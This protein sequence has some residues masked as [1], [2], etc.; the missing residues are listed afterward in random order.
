LDTDLQLITQIYAV[1]FKKSLSAVASKICRYETVI[2]VWKWQWNIV[3]YKNIYYIHSGIVEN[4]LQVRDNFIL[5]LL[6][7]VDEKIDEASQHTYKSAFDIMHSALIIDIH[8]LQ[9]P[10]NFTI[11]FVLSTFCY[12]LVL[13]KWGLK[14]LW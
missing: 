8:C 14:Y 6:A 1:W 2:L 4:I 3:I 9:I 5:W 11:P 12:N 13:Y 7:L 10:I